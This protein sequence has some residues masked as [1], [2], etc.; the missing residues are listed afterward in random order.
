MKKILL[1]ALSLVALSAGLFARQWLSAAANQSN[2]A[3][4][5]SLAVSF[6]DLQT[7]SRSLEEWK[8]KVLVVNFW[9]T[10]CGPCLE[11]MPEFVKLQNELNARGL[12]FVGVAIDDLSSVKEFLKATPVNYPILIGE[13]NGVE[14][15]SKWGNHV[16]AL[17]FTVVF[18]RSGK[19][20]HRQTGPFKRESLLEVLQP[21]L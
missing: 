20:I 17:P 2:Q 7:K 6:P 13:E 18:D 12:Q 10:W 19:A 11:E 8:G 9:A 1:I 16:Q 15:A 5:A 21:L 3:A 14:V 4:A